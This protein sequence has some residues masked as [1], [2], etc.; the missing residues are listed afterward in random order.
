MNCFAISI[1]LGLQHGVPLERYV[2]SFVQTRFEPNG[3]VQHHD[4]IKNATSLMDLIFRHLAIV[5]L[6]R[7][8]LA[9]LPVTAEDLRGDAVTPYQPLR[10]GTD[11]PLPTFA[12]GSPY[13]ARE[14]AKQKG[15]AG[16][17]CSECHQFTLIANGTCFKC[18]TCHATTGCS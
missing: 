14:E 5:Y 1:S 9:H 7:Q 15:Y 16:N 4:N 12:G 3:P 13:S 8:D 2:D 11:T 17:P 6:N 10:A 18:D